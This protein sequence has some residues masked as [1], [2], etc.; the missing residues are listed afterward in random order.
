MIITPIEIGSVKAAAS[1]RGWTHIKR[2]YELS[3]YMKY[4]IKRGYYDWDEN[5]NKYWVPEK[6]TLIEGEYIDYYVKGS[7]HACSV[8]SSLPV[9]DDGVLK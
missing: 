6:R 8:A 9:F 3:S 4:V 5:D 7:L 1:K 2:E